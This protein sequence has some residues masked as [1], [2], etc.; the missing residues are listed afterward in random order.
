MVKKNMSKE[1]DCFSDKW[2]ILFGAVKL[3]VV[4]M[5]SFLLCVSLDE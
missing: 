2:V 3:K 4:F 1:N 5:Y